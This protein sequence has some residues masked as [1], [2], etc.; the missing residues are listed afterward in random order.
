MWKEVKEKDYKKAEIGD[1]VFHGFWGQRKQGE[2]RIVCSS[3]ENGTRKFTWSLHTKIRN[4]EVKIENNHKNLYHA[5]KRGV[6]NA[7][8][9]FGLGG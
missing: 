8:N 2:A 1:C 3:S 7:I 5:A 9:R 6:V 4:N